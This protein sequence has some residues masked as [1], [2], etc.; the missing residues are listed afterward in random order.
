MQHLEIYHREVENQINQLQLSNNPPELYEPIRYL[1][2]NG[3]KR[4]RPLL[5]ML[6]C[7]LFGKPGLSALHAGVAVEL[8]HNFTLIHDDIMDKAPLRRGKTSV[9][10]KWSENSALLSGDTLFVVAYRELIKHD[11]KFLPELIPVFSKTAQEVCEGQQMDMDFETRDE[12]SI[13]EYIEM[14][15]LKTAVLLAGALE[16]GAIIGEA[17]TKNRQH[18]YRFGEHI[19]IAFQLQDDLLDVYAD[20]KTFG[21]QVG[22]DI[23]ANKKTFLLLK[24]KELSNSEQSAVFVELEHENNH[25]VKVSRTKELFEQLGVRALAKEEMTRHFQLSLKHLSQIE[26]SDESKQPLKMLAHMLM[27]RE[28]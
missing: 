9:H 14:I 10:I 7:Q 23:I 13:D 17:N 6:S 19:G 25:E 3:G 21:K 28:Q 16:M 4:I 22:G 1:L 2:S 18:I 12:V 8:F 20:S 15:R 27:D 11:A 5:S 24:A 26:A